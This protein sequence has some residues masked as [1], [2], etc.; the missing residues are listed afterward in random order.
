M[1]SFILVLTLTGQRAVKLYSEIIKQQLWLK[2]KLDIKTVKVQSVHFFP[3]I[4]KKFYT[5][6]D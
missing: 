2:M 3:F 4:K 5:I 1:C 6:N